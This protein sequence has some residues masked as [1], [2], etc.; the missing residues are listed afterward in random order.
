M[1]SDHSLV[2]CRKVGIIADS[3]GQ[4]QAIAD[5]IDVL[6]QKGCGPIYHLGDVC[7]SFLP[8]TSG[9]CVDLLL[10]KGVSAVKGNN[11]HAIVINHRGQEGTIVSGRTL[12]YLHDLPLILSHEG[13]VFTH[14]LP[15]IEELGLSSM[16][17]VMKEEWARRFFD[18]F[19]G[20]ILFRGHGHTPRIRWSD[21]GKFLSEVLEIDHPIDLAGRTPCV[22]TCGALTRGLCMIWD[23]LEKT[24]TSLSFN[25]HG[26]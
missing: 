16:I 11:D 26:I 23:T 4:P 9:T 2:P 8:E 1:L 24:L 19:P 12:E 22:V 18:Q 6:R 17:G 7:D 14:S 3:H 5:A 20:G 10:T 13:A 25:P 15:F 21:R